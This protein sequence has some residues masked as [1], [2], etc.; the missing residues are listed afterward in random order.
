MAIFTPLP[1]YLGGEIA[2]ST[3]HI[4]GLVVPRASLDAVEERKIPYLHRGS[5]S[6]CPAHIP[7]LNRTTYFI[8]CR[9]QKYHKYFEMEVMTRK[10][11]GSTFSYQ[12]ISEVVYLVF[13]CSRVT[14]T[15]RHNLRYA[16][17]D[18]LWSVWQ[19]SPLRGTG[20]DDVAGSR[21]ISFIAVGALFM[22]FPGCGLQVDMAAFLFK[23]SVCCHR[24]RFQTDAGSF[25]K[26]RRH[27]DVSH[28][29]QF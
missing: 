5:N 15:L 1:L 18:D 4:G 9:L 10:H 7:S 23:S 11:H 20:I 16:R 13:R 29:H 19:L 3:Y 8:F 28:V 6:G 25:K 21:M 2:H 14:R 17:R 24:N 26:R 27:T 22:W 12:K